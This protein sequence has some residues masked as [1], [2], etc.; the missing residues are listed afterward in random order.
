[1]SQFTNQLRANLSNFQEGA[2]RR[3]RTLRVWLR[4]DGLQG[5]L[6]KLAR[7]LQDFRRVRRAGAAFDRSL[8]VETAAPVGLWHLR[9]PSKN[10]AHA[11]RYQAVD[12]NALRRLLR[13]IQTDWSSFTFIDLGCGKGRALIVANEFG[14][15]RLIGVEFAAKLARTATRNCRKLGLRAEI[16]SQDAAE[17]LFPPGKLAVYLNNPFGPRVLNCVLDHLLETNTRD[18]Y[19]LYVYPLHRHCLEGRPG[20]EPMITNRYWAV[21]KLAPPSK[22]PLPL[23]EWHAP[24]HPEH[25]S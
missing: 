3:A 18:S 6:R 4:K 22:R 16:L 25:S 11:E 13:G 2:T 19:L 5:V 23:L 15:E 9:I 21:W 14:F 1:V 8:G 10:L 20:F 17:F 7:Y 12:P 24:R